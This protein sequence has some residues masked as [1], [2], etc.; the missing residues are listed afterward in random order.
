MC[1]CNG[2]KQHMVFG[3]VIASTC[4][5]IGMWLERWNIIVPTLNHPNLIPWSRYAPTWPEWALI[6]ASFALFVLFFVIFF[7][8]FP[9]V[10]IWEVMEG[11][12]IHEAETRIVIPAPEPS[13]QP[14]R[15]RV[16]GERIRDVR[17]HL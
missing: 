3:T 16:F 9:P 15:R 14:R 11:R 5:V 12:V 8:L 4:I 10:S 6:V 1:C 17:S 7:K 13:A 2:Y